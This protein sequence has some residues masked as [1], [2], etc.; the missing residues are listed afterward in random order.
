[1]NRAPTLAPSVALSFTRLVAQMMLAF[2]TLYGVITI[3]GGAARW[4]SP[5]YEVALQVPGAPQSWGAVL[6]GASI[7]GMLGFAVGAQPVIMVGFALCAGWATCFALCIG[8]VAARNEAVGW[9]GVVTWAMIAL[10]YAACT[11]AGR[12]RFHAPAD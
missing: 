1:M 12:G 5:A 2:G 10:M 11:A 9:G 6:F 8:L 4:G 7:V 3:V